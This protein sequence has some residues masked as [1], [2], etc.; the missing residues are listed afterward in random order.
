M[1]REP[2]EIVMRYPVIEVSCSRCERI[3]H[4]PAHVDA[5]R[6]HDSSKFATLEVSLVVGEVTEVS[7]KLQDLCA[8]CLRTVRKHLQSIQKPIKGHSPN[9]SA[10][11]KKREVVARATRPE[12][13]LEA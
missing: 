11:P 7:C 13:S 1:R 9:R 4:V 5:D 2:W 6:P 8:P 3:E 12:V 10:Q